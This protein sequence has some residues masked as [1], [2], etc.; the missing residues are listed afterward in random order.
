MHFGRPSSYLSFLRIRASPQF[1]RRLPETFVDAASL[2]VSGK[3]GKIRHRKGVAMYFRT[4]I[5]AFLSPWTAKCSSDSFPS[6][7]LDFFNLWLD[8]YWVRDF[9]RVPKVAGMLEDFLDELND[10]GLTD[11]ANRLKLLIIKV[12]SVIVSLAVR[13]GPDTHCARSESARLT[14]PKP[15]KSGRPKTRQLCLQRK[16]LSLQSQRSAKRALCRKGRRRP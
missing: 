10:S 4:Q 8:S 5:S 7:T 3:V 11:F 13:L 16:A 6:R 15:F 12:C 14:S 2:L 1:R 9:E